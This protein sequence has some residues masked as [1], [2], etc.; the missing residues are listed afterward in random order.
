MTTYVYPS[1]SLSLSPSP[2]E[3][4]P[5]TTTRDALR[6]IPKSFFILYIPVYATFEIRYRLFIITGW[7]RI[8]ATSWAVVLFTRYK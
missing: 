3:S 5:T 2:L 1:D 8:V 4:P 6:Y 7:T